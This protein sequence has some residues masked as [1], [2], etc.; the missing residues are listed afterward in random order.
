MGCFLGGCRAD[1]TGLVTLSVDEVAAMLAKGSDV[2]LC[3]ANNDDTRA[4]YGVVPGAILLS[5]YKDYDPASV[6]PA[7][8]ARRVVFY[9]H[10]EMCGAAAGAARRA[11]AAGWSNVSV[12]PAGIKGWVA[13]DQPVEKPT[14][15]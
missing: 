12:M 2:V 9:C 13:D 10:S 11:M 6:L 8:G 14:S 1:T 5:S 7:D 15:S 3:D 4:K